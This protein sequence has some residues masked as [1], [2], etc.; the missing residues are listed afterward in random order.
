MSLDINK[1]RQSLEKSSIYFIDYYMLDGKCAMIKAYM[2]QINQF[3]FIYIPTKL[4]S[5]LSN[6]NCYE[7]KT[8]EEV[9]DEE[10]YAKY[11]EYQ[12]NFVRKNADKDIYKNKTQQYN[13]TISIHGDGI[14][15]IEKRM[16]R[17]IKRI[18][19]PFSKLDYTIGIHN[20]KIL[21]LHF[22]EEINLFYIK[23]YTKDTRCYMYIMNVKEIID[24][25]TEISDEL[26]TINKQFYGIIYDIIKKNISEL[27]YEKIMD[28]FEIHKLNYD[29]KVFDFLSVI[30][31]IEDE[32]KNEIKKYKDLFTKE[33]SSIRKTS[34]EREYQKSL[35]SINSKKT[36][37]IEMIINMTSQFQ[38]I[39]LLLEE[40]SFDNYI[41][42]KRTSTNYEKLKAMFV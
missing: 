2:Y 12:I 26:E 32:E 20:K 34:L 19:S 33:Q 11:D 29:K 28:Y 38:I 23:N 41:M 5:E 10:D 37:K 13:K 9:V 15:Q 4:R 40:I 8:L 35:S 22:G 31:K 18:N 39:F 42:T 21:T 27:Q 6:K 3:L 25:L 24:N 16:M 1:L 36:E 14:E 7:L 17:Q 30:K